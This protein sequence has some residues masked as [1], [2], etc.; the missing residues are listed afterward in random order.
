MRTKPSQRTHCV[1]LWLLIGYDG[2]ID[3]LPP[4]MSLYIAIRQSFVPP[5]ILTAGITS[6]NSEQWAVTP[7]VAG[8]TFLIR[9]AKG[10]NVSSQTSPSLIEFRGSSINSSVG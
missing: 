10:N 9:L 8:A 2:V 3:L 1:D 6:V 4:S 7:A 5:R